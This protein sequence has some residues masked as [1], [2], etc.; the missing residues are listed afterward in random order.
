MH[1]ASDDPSP[2][3]PEGQPRADTAPGAAPPHRSAE[4]LG[5]RVGGGMAWML[6]A[7]VTA[8]LSTLGAQIVLG[9][10]LAE[11]DFG[12]YAAAIG[13]AAFI[14]AFRDGGVRQ[15]LIQKGSA[16]WEGLAG[17]AFWLA[18]LVNLTMAALLALAAAAIYALPIGGATAY[19]D[20]RLPAVLLVLAAALAAASP[21]LIFQARLSTQL[22]FRSVAV[23]NTQQALVRNGSMI[24]FALLGFGPLSF[25]LPIL[26]ATLYVNVCGYYLTR[27]RLWTRAPR[28]RL[29]PAMIAR[30]KWLVLMAIALAALL[31]GD[32]FVLGWL[33]PAGL[34]G[35]YFFAYQITAQIQILLGVNLQLVLFPALSKLRHEPQRFRAATLRA[36]RVLSLFACG[37][38]VGLALVYDPLQRL[39]WG[40][41][42]AATVPA[43]QIMAVS[44]PFRM[45]A[46]VMNSAMMARGLY[47]PLALLTLT[48]GGGLML[49]A[50]AAAATTWALMGDALQTIAAAAA[51][52]APDGPAVGS[53][54]GADHALTMLAAFT[55][56][57]FVLGVTALTLVGLR[58]AGAPAFRVLA[59]ILP[60]WTLAVALGAALYAIE[61][62]ASA[63]AGAQ[64]PPALRIVALGG[65]FTFAYALG[66][67]S[68]VPRALDDSLAVLPARLAAP[69]RRLLRL[70]RNAGS[71]E[72]PL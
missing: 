5:K 13:L 35:L 30:G 53:I 55:A 64:L 60:V 32:Y 66:V 58:K 1:P 12:V 44:F 10:L 21:V 2:D 31:Q 34:V 27:D 39:I 67:R 36:V 38:G 29:W 54:A 49:A 15:L 57:F 72:P 17:A 41:K 9:L 6:L 40:E 45:L 70:P 71:D 43:V 4:A 68:L 25:A 28:R 48:A 7:T 65:A 19:A 3:R 52:A 56:A 42:W 59:G 62:A 47:K 16:H 50:A 69:T 24:V 37:A 46:N 8:K 61:H 22:R 20:P 14:Q 26:V 33:V 51:E 23:M 63:A 11:D 18:S